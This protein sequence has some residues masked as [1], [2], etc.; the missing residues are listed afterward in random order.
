LADGFS[1]REDAIGYGEGERG[2][3]SFLDEAALDAIV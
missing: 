2:R 3:E 1:E